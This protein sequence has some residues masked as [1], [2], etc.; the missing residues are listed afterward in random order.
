[1]TYRNFVIFKVPPEFY[2]LKEINV[3]TLVDILSDNVKKE[4]DRQIM[5]ELKDARDAKT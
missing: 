5:K 1:M 2:D 3:Q 4:I